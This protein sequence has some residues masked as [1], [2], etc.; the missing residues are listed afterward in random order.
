MMILELDLRIDTE[1]E[2]NV[3]EK[4]FLDSIRFVK[5]NGATPVAR[6]KVIAEVHNGSCS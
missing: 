4:L 3:Y 6:E 2:I 1:S 5:K